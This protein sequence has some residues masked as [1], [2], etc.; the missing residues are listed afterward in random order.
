MSIYGLIYNFI[1]TIAAGLLLP[2]WLPYVLAKKKYRVSFICRSGFLS[3]EIKEKLKRK[4]NI[5][6]HAVS[7]GEFNLAATLI[8][9]LRP[10]CPKVQFVVSVTTLTGYEVASKKLTDADILIFFP[11]ELFTIMNKIVGL[12]NPK[13]AVIIETEIWPNFVYSLAKRGCPLILS[14]GRLSEKSFGRYKLVKPFIKDVL[15]NFARFNMQTERDAKRIIELG[16][17]KNKVSITGNIKFDSAKIVDCPE[18]DEEIISEICIPPN[19][20]IFLAAALEK[21]GREDPIAINVFEKLREKFPEAALIIVPRH[22][23]RGA[24]IAKLVAARGC[25]PRLRSK[26]EKF[27]NPKK[28]IF[29]LDTVGEL[30]RF[31][32][33]AKIVFVGKSLFKPGGGQNMIE[34]VAL[35]LPVIYGKYTGNFRGIADVL[36][37]HGGAKIVADEN[38]LANTIINLWE[39]QEAA[40][41]MVARGQSYIRAQQGATQKNIN[42]IL[43]L[44]NL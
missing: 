1:G 3:N 9:K 26:K 40:A 13:V 31:Y 19:T 29:I 11:T 23:E 6:I 20:P 10:L 41:E 21:T 32:T 14:N 22:P 4:P 43:S 35:G 25:V 17:Q 18:K 39:N 16:A 38:E 8:E 44:L 28:Q 5:W 33:L 24:D 42:K 34:P 36:A 27:D 7:V 12:V 37:S 2:L 15:K 30:A